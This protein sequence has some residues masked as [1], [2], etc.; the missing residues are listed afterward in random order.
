MTAPDVVAAPV[1]SVTAPAPAGRVV[2]G[3]Q[4]EDGR[5]ITLR[6]SSAADAAALQAFVRGLSAESR[7]HRF[8]VGLAEL[9]PRL[10]ATMAGAD[11][12]THIALVAYAPVYGKT[13]MVGEARA[14]LDASGRTADFAIAVAED[15][16]TA[17]IGSRLLRAIEDA[18][19]AAG[20]ERLTGDVLQGN[21]KA[22]DFLRQRGFAART[23]REEPRLMRVDK[24]LSGKAIAAGME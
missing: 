23:N 10:L 11:Q 7:Y 4:L 20:V 13:L 19:R 15:W 14:V 8:L 22:L 6:Q 9:P 16:Q 2:A 3:W 21:H 5:A 1:V 18:A 12:R 17:G 24:P